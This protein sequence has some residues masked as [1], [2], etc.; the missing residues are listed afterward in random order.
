MHGSIATNGYR[1][2]LDPELGEGCL[3]CS[4]PE[5]LAHLFVECP[6]LAPV[7]VLLRAWFQGLG[8]VFSFVLFIFGPRYVA[9]NKAVHTLLNFLSGTAK[10]AIWLTRRNRAQDQGAV[11]PAA[12]LEGLLKARLRVEHSYYRMTDNLSAFDRIWA[13]GGVLCSVGEDG[14]LLVNF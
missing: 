1:A 4:Q 10:L 12:M 8:E 14:D 11:E 5:T 9:K 2:H 3:F 13:V 7:F 6:R